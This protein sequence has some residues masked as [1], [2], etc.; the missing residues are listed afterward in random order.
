MGADP[1]QLKNS[2][3][4]VPSPTLKNRL[5]NSQIQQS[6]I[7]LDFPILGNSGDKIEDKSEIKI[8]VEPETSTLNEMENESKNTVESEIINETEIKTQPQIENQIE[9]TDKEQ[10]NE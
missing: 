8:D 3:K 2:S 10:M 7:D 6:D 5:L 1:E 4:L 9:T